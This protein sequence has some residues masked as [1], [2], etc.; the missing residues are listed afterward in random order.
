MCA[1]RR[2]QGRR[3]VLDIEDYKAAE[4]RVGEWIA[5]SSFMRIAGVFAAAILGPQGPLMD[6]NLGDWTEHSR[7]TSWIWPSRGFAA[8]PE[9]AWLRRLLFFAGG[10]AAYA[11]PMFPLMPLQRLHWSGLSKTC[12]KT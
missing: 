8:G 7:S 4:A 12:T 11:Y 2:R 5:N 6:S 9:A 1:N 10:G 3:L